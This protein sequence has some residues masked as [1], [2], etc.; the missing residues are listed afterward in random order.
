MLPNLVRTDTKLV[1]STRSL[2]L[3]ADGTSGFGTKRTLE[4]LDDRS[5]DQNLAGAITALWV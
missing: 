4:I 2:A 1:K 5:V 3:I